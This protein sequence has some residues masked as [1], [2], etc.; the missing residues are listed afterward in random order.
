MSVHLITQGLDSRRPFVVP[1][2]VAHFKEKATT[3]ELGNLHVERE[4]NDVRMVCDIYLRLL[5]SAETGETYNI[6]TSQTYTLQ[7]IIA[8]LTE[9]TGHTIQV[10]VNPAFVRANE[11][12]R[13]CGNSYKID[14]YH[15]FFA[16]V[17]HL[18]IL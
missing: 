2:I 4:Y 16:K 12:H 3:I 15:W 1:K 13:L 8:T 6:C 14:Q 10:K 11:V 7:Q 9:L 18:E 5:T 17:M